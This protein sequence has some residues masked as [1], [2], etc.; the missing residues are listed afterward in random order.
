MASL[1]QT[2][3]NAV[4]KALLTRAD[5]AAV[6]EL[7]ARFRLIELEGSELRGAKWK[8]G[9]KIQVRLGTITFRTY[10]PVSWD[11][12]NGRLSLL[13]YLGADGPGMQWA[14]E[15][16]AGES[17]TFRGP[18]RAVNLPAGDGPIVFF[19]DET[20]IGTAAAIR[21]ARPGAADRFV[22]EVS[23]ATEVVAALGHFGLTDAIIVQRGP[24]RARVA[25]RAVASARTET[26]AVRV[27][28]T[29]RVKSM[30]KLST[31]L[32][33]GGGASLRQLRS[34]PYWM[35]GIPGLD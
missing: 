14:R 19:G 25:A 5:V 27:L 2:V 13:V 9:D 24:E 8:P 22:I 30:R 11:R 32:V 20:A 12:L 6:T 4:E 35:D 1:P 3:M 18:S 21:A 29:G 23:A 26:D 28:L 7:G 16:R 10:T 31:S 33:A 34:K 15:L 17:C